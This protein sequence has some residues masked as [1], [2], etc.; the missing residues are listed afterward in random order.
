M[1]KVQYLNKK[2]L[3]KLPQSFVGETHYEVIMGSFAYGVSNVESDID[4]YGV[5]VPPK[6]MVFP[7]L[8]GYIHGF[9]PSPAN[10]ENFQQHHIKDKEIEYD[11]SIYSIIQYVN[12]AMDNNPN[13]IDSLFVPQRCV[14]HI[15]QIGNILRENKLKFLHK[16]SYHR[17]KGYAYAQLKKLKNGVSKEGRKELVEKYGMDVKFAYHIVRL[18]AQA[19]MI[20]IEHDLDLERNK[21]QL[22]SIRNGEWTLQRLED[23]F[24][25]KEKQLDEL[26][27]NSKLCYRPDY[28]EIK[29]ILLCCLEHK[30]GNL[31]S[32]YQSVDTSIIQKYNKI[33]KVINGEI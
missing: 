31:S 30:Y 16:G 4:L 26:Y 19:E 17:Y 11:V 33:L 2:E 1:S 24:Q 3:L 28:D 25:T 14:V 22:K 27:L 8:S 18:A 9:G 10:F 32:F 21:E 5:C 12:L 23:W 13:I 29:R 6:E 15:D 20:L 7:H